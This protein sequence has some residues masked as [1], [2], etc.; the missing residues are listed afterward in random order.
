M[1]KAG[2]SDRAVTE[3]VV[4]L[5]GLGRSAWSM[6]RL[7]RFFGAQGYVVWCKTYP[8]RRH[9]IEQLAEHV[10]TDV[11]SDER[12]LQSEKIHFVTHSLG[13]ILLR[14]WFQMPE[15]FDTSHLSG[16]SSKRA[17]S[18]LCRAE[19]IGR[20]VMLGAPN[21]GSEVTEFF[22]HWPLYQWLTGPAGSQLG[23]R[24]DD[25]PRC[26]NAIDLDVGVIA[27]TR[28]ADPWFT[29]L[30]SGEH[31]GKVSVS[32]TRLTE[33]ADFIALP[34]GHTLMMWNKNVIEQAHHFIREGRF[35]SGK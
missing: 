9:T 7:A 22:R 34:V 21:Q 15:R 2:S 8:S 11:F 19:H 32:S 35:L 28:S 5:H 25:L 23:T 12:V 10:F 24:E 6:Q 3:C 26:L 1:K 33:M 30:F 14:Q 31:D 17:E 27:G 13:G 16:V 29:F 18:A 20:V 4:L